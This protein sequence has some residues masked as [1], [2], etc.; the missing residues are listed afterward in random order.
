MAATLLARMFRSTPGVGICNRSAVSRAS[1]FNLS[2]DDA[3]VSLESPYRR[4]VLKL[5]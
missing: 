4:G 1:I 3:D 2:G 5:T